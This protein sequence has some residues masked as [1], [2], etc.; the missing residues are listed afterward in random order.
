MQLATYEG[1]DGVRVGVVEGDQ[2]WDLAPAAEASGLVD[3]A[4]VTDMRA[5]LETGEAGLD[6]VRAT[7]MWATNN[8]RS[9]LSVSLQEV[10]LLAPL[11]C[12]GKLMCLAGNY[13]S[14]IEEGGGSYIGKEK[15][16][17]RFFIKPCSSVTCHRTA[18]PHPG[19]HRLRRLG[20]RTRRRHRQTR[21][22]PDS[23][24]G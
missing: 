18:D 22:R 19:F 9:D 11:P 7:T 4:D 8:N 20:A 3:T 6:A 5:L 14:H 21:P 24:T 12:P 1:L 17:P 15:M 13:A 23:R 2:I 16:I 10:T